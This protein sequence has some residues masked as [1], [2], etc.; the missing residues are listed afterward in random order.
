MAT[1]AD[2]P[3][4]QPITKFR[5]WF[6]ADYKSSEAWRLEAKKDFGFTE[7]Y[8]Q[9]PPDQAA[10]IIKEQNRYPL[11]FNNILPTV[12]V[13]SGQER[14]SR[15]GIVLKPRGIEDDTLTMIGNGALR[16]AEEQSDQIFEVSD[17]FTDMTICGRGWVEM[18]M[19]F[20]N[21]D[22]PL[23]ELMPRR[24]HPLCMFWDASADEYSLQDAE[25]IA[26]AS[27][28]QEDALRL[29]FPKAMTDIQD[30]EWTGRDA[31]M[32]GDTKY[33]EQWVDK[34]RKRIRVLQVW[35]K[36]PRRAF[37]LIIHADQ[38]VH[39]FDTEEAANG[40]RNAIV[41]AYSAAATQSPE[42]TIVSRVVKDVRVADVVY[43][44]IL[45]DRPS[46]YRHNRF[47]FVPM[48]AFQ[49]DEVLMGV[50][51]NLRDPQIEKNA[52]W[53]QM[54]HIVNTMAKGNMRVPKGSLD[55]FEDFKKNH[56]KAGYA[57]EYNASIGAPEP[58]PSPPFP[59]SLIELAALSEDE[60]RKISGAV[61]EL[62]GI[63]RAPDQSGKAINALKAGGVTVIAPL[64]DSLVRSLRLIGRQDIDLI[65][66]YYPAE[67]LASIVGDEVAKRIKAE[68]MQSIAA[69][70]MAIDPLMRFSQALNTRYDSIVDTAP[71]L[72][73][74][75]ERQLQ[76]LTAV[77][78]ATAKSGM[79]HMLPF[80]LRS[81][82]EVSDFPNKQQAIQ[83][84]SQMP[85]GM[86]AQQQEQGGS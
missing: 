30:G 34:D 3:Q 17:A 74:E 45:A 39:R 27:W 46:P 47:P 41:Q 4:K 76:N 31:A 86:F 7:G 54:L 72:G 85:A 12:N 55:N 9:I 49:L 11:I 24:R 8:G 50:V 79:I 53:R 84:L 58:E 65:Q 57:Y 56:G 32:L 20:E 71:I 40:A 77:Y 44:K 19:D 37:L 6:D 81:I 75:R 43:W 29:Y 23:G 61:Q 14:A 13:I 80:L 22:E 63:S 66:Q 51:R 59:T 70:G 64:F 25:R 35:Y 68:S 48:T 10:K 16:Y 67:K 15:L 26:R 28:V 69:G 73:S 62:L 78:E 2:T 1:N 21:I 38:T 82:Y 18:G 52:R 83:A 5:E 36:V 33:Q 42:M 60:I